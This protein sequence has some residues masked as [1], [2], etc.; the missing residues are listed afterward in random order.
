MLICLP[1]QIADRARRDFCSPQCFCN[2][3]YAADRV[4]Q[5]FFDRTFTP[6]SFNNGGFEADSFSLGILIIGELKLLIFKM[7]HSI[8]SAA[9]A[10]S[11]FF[12]E[13]FAKYTGKKDFKT[14]P[15]FCFG[16]RSECLT[17][18]GAKRFNSFFDLDN[19]L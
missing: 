9:N 15:I 12:N 8:L 14:I 7:H 10:S 18:S 19:S 13:R 17:A 16:K 6:V 4:D 1:V 3:F 5:S 11:A 2:I